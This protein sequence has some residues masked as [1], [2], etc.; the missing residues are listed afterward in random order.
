MALLETLD[1]RHAGV[2]AGTLSEIHVVAERAR[3][4]IWLRTGELTLALGRL[5]TLAETC[6]QRG[7]ARRVPY[8]QLQSAAALR[9][10][11]R[12]DDARAKVREALRLGHRLGL[13]RSLLD[14]H[15]DAL[16]MVR[17]AIADQTLDQVLL[18]YAERLEAAG[19]EPGGGARGPR[20]PQRPGFEV[21]SPREGEI[22]QLLLQNLPNKKIARA[23]DLSLDTV[24]WHLKNVYGKLGASGRDDVVERLRR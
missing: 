13:V 21:L 12:H 9:Q 1:A 11:G 2:Q 6:R 5:E 15:E 3:I 7:R 14:A 22:V 23:L 16:P 20:R 18:F 24:K 8:L 19:R 4:R 17:E 10:L